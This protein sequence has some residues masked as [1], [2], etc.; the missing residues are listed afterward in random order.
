M[1]FCDNEDND[2]VEGNSKLT[3]GLIWTI[4]L[5]FQVSVIKQRQLESS[6]CQVSFSVFSQQVIHIVQSLHWC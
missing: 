4:I 5:N 1:Y 3:L 6:S 2:I